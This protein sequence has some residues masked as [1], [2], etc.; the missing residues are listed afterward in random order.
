[1]WRMREKLNWSSQN[2]QDKLLLGSHQR[3]RESGAQ[4]C[5][6]WSAALLEISI[7]TWQHGQPCAAAGDRGKWDSGYKEKQLSELARLLHRGYIDH[8]ADI[9][10]KIPTCAKHKNTQ[11]HTRQISS[12]K[13][14]HSFRHE[15]A[16]KTMES[17][18]HMI[19][20]TLRLRLFTFRNIVC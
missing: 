8:L 15:K 9:S 3:I 6:L 20:Y 16:E 7:G 2:I 1:M 10:L 19:G 5:S 11:S 12:E 14:F 18:W 17:I 13:T 4:D